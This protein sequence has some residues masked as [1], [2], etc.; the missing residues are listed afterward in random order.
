MF[1]EFLSQQFSWTHD[2][3]EGKNILFISKDSLFLTNVKKYEVSGMNYNV[4]SLDFGT[5]YYW[6]VSV[7][8]SGGREYISTIRSFSTLQYSL[9]GE[10]T[11]TIKGPHNIDSSG[12]RTTRSV[13]DL[14]WIS[15][16]LSTLELKVLSLFRIINS[17]GNLAT[18]LRLITEL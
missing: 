16:I 15:G 12:T 13:F 17:Q 2:L 8:S 1:S 4:D 14:I 6:Y 5:K 9:S 18:V 11:I 7:S 10:G 3:K